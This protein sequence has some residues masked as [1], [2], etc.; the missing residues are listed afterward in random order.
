[1]LPN[2]RVACPPNLLG[3]A[4]GDCVKSIGRKAARKREKWMRKRYA[5]VA[6]IREQG[7]EY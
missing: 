4:D 2:R 1:M 3:V 5:I 6:A 7:G